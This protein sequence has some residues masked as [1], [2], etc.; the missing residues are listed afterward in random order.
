MSTW[1]E[2]ERGTV[3]VFIYLINC[4]QMSNAENSQKLMLVLIDGLRYDLYG[5]DMPNL[6]RIAREGVRAKLT[7]PVYPTETMPSMYS[8]ATGLYTESHG[9][10]RNNYFNVNTGEIY[11]FTKTCNTSEW[12]DTGAEPIWV[13]A[14]FSGMT[15]GTYMYPGGTVE[16][17]GVRPDRDVANTEWRWYNL[18]FQER[19][20]DVIAWLREDDLDVIL[21]YFGHLDIVLHETGRDSRGTKSKLLEVDTGIGY[22]LE[23][24]E[25]YNFLDNMNIIFTSDHGH[26][27]ASG[28][29]RIWDFISENDVAFYL[30]GND[31]IGVLQPKNGRINKVYQKLKNAHPKLKVYKKNEIPHHYHY[32]NNDRVLDIL[33]EAEPPWT[34]IMSNSSNAT[35]FEVHGYDPSYWKMQ[36]IFYAY[37][38]RFKVGYERGPFDSV[39]IY[40]LMCELLGLVPAPCNGSLHNV[41]DLLIDNSHWWDR[42]TPTRLLVAIVVMTTISVLIRLNTM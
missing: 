9:V 15:T 25:K 30:P 42:I 8:I 33:L 34:L 4:R 18:S 13:T 27:I 26:S 1:T 3:L 16:I 5:A 24:L 20:D 12:L 10:V 32:K 28:T 40:P 22:L 23:Q 39:D 7:Y 21:L 38:P 2:L 6:A 14:H 29:I 37:G 11:S 35:Y 17:K 31:P 36:S 41:K 19:I